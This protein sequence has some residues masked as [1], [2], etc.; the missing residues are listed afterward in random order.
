MKRSALLF[1]CVALWIVG[2]ACFAQDKRAL[3]GLELDSAPLPELL[4]KHLGLEA[5]QGVRIRNIVVDSPADK[6][7]LER[8]DLIVAFQG[9]KVTDVEQVVEGVRG[10]N[11]GDEMSL[12]VIHLGQ[13]K[14][15]QVKLEAARENPQLKYPP[16]PEAMTTWRPGKVF[17]VGPG[18]REWMEVP[19]D[20]MPEFNVDANG[21]MK[22][23]HTFLHSDD[24]ENYM[25]TIEGDPKDD[26]STV[27][28]ESG[29]EEYRTTVGKLDAIPEKY[30]DQVREAVENARHDRRSD[31]GIGRKFRL[32]EPP[33]PEAYREFLRSIPRPDMEQLAEQ[34]GRALEKIQEQMERLQE[35]MQALEERNREMLDR[36]LD[37][38]DAPKESVPSPENSASVEPGNGQ[39]I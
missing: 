18:G 2:S 30:R 6:A 26:N 14:T 16:E 11:V 38:K 39:S 37:K 10:G 5:G 4:T 13:H 19:F 28:V 20:K 29:T 34:K 7:G 31:V 36:L 24:G 15:L 17:R 23:V 33:R 21:F 3:M 1:G 8:D 25:I 9:K 32:P 27:T 22:E 35:R 12:E